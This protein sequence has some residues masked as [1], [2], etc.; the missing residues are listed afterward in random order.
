LAELGSI[1][2]LLFV[3]GGLY[4]LIRGADHLVDGSSALALKMG[5][6]PL[7]IGL[8]LVAFGTSAPELATCL[9]AVTLQGELAPGSL[10]GPS[11]LALGNVV[12]S[13][14]CNLAF[15]LGATILLVRITVDSSLLRREL[16]FL[17][18]LTIGF[19]TLVQTVG[20][21]RGGGIGLLV[22]F[23]AFC[24]W[25]SHESIKQRRAAKAGRDAAAAT[26]DVDVEALQL[27]D[28]SAAVGLIVLGL[29]VL[30]TGAELLV[31]SAGALA[32]RLHVPQEFIGLSIV[33]LGTSLPELATT[34]VAARKGTL[35]LGLG[36]V[37]GSNV[38]NIG[39]V[40]GL[41]AT[42]HAW[43]IDSEAIAFDMGVML[44]LTFLVGVVA[45]WRRGLG[46]RLGF[47]LLAS[48][49]A[50]VTVL[51]VGVLRPA[52]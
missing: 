27:M 1:W 3:I 33:A 32:T 29:V 42:L 41:P 7:L 40:V 10:P 52:S 43:P 13:N 30:T 18:V 28:S 12:G 37:I 35:E 17:L 26:D 8:T 34:L 16:P 36:A 31:L 45:L 22:A 38:F 15:V 5:V 50:Y 25:S 9:R 4:L 39:L 48:Y 21:T 46:R 44:A 19:V 6:S 2:L 14:I 11:Q 20:L 47:V 23:L 24:V 49:A 51:L